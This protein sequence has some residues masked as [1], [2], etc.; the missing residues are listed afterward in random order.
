MEQHSGY[1]QRCLQLA[2]LGLG[3][4]APN[5]LVGAVLVHGGRIIG[6]GYH[7]R[8]G[9]PHAEVNCIRSVRQE[10]V[11]LIPGATLYVS[12]E[13]CAH[14]GKTPPCTDLILRS[15]IPHVVIGSMDPFP[16]VNGRGVARLR[17]AGVDVITGVEQEACDWLN[18]RFITFHTR[19]RPYVILKWARS[20]NG[21]MASGNGQRLMITNAL[22]DRLVHKWRSEEAAI[23]VGTNTARADDPALTNRHWYG[24]DPVRLV[25]DM[26]LRLPSHLKLFDRKHPTIVFNALRQEEQEN[27][28]LYKVS[29]D[30]GRV[31]HVLDALR[32]LQL[33]SVIVEGGAILLR[34]FI[35]EG[36]W[37]E[38]RVITNTDL[39]VE[40]GRS[41]PEIPGYGRKEEMRLQND[42]VTVYY[43]S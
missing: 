28:R 11:S 9:G 39:H 43:P 36:Y 31:E 6:E 30:A 7:E 4:V 19:H 2:A 5:P 25:V 33:Q 10:D 26:D 15:G 20:A 17:E 12:L 32:T 16:E 41:A 18:R 1:M 29:R 3:H 14:F 42:L 34:S 24:R 40:D 35:Q 23:M 13:P 27:L 37:D 21:K 8:F 22:S 38:I